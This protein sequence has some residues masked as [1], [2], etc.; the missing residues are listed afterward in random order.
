MEETSIL[1]VTELSILNGMLCRCLHRHLRCTTHEIWYPRALLYLMYQEV[2]ELLR[3]KGQHGFKQMQF[4][5]ELPSLS[6]VENSN[7]WTNLALESPLLSLDHCKSIWIKEWSYHKL[8]GNDGEISFGWC[9][10]EN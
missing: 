7:N 8:C 10:L 9:F 1:A 5:S 4:N 6:R 2:K 3:I